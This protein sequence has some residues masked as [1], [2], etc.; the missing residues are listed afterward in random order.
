M[1][2]SYRFRMGPIM[3][4]FDPPRIGDLRQPEPVNQVDT[5][6]NKSA[7]PWELRGF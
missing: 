5:L 7:R 6:D 2:F 3:P 1:A 4:Q